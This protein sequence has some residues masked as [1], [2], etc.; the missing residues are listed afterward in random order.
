MKITIGP[1]DRRYVRHRDRLSKPMS[2]LWPIDCGHLDYRRASFGIKHIGRT[3]GVH[4]TITSAY[5]RNTRDVTRK[6]RRPSAG[7][8]GYRPNLCAALMNKPLPHRPSMVNGAGRVNETL[9][10]VSQSLCTKSAGFRTYLGKHG[11]M[12]GFAGRAYVPNSP[13]NVQNP[14]AGVAQTHR[15][16][17]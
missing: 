6:R 14:R 10:V 17:R 11:E 9:T 13:R 15:P 7:A 16:M 8:I 4:T 1:T 12:G 2:L 3:T 5:R